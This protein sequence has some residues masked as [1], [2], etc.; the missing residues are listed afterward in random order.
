VG[1]NS[2]ANLADDGEAPRMQA[3]TPIEFDKKD[4]RH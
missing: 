3:G 2:T 1:Q 4:W